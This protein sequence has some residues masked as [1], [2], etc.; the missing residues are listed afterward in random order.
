LYRCCDRKEIAVFFGFIILQ[1]IPEELP[2]KILAV[3]KPV[4]VN[5]VMQHNGGVADNKFS[6]KKKQQNNH[7]LF[8][9]SKGVYA[10][11]KAALQYTFI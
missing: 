10:I 11:V 7:F 6:G 3:L 2:A 9:C 1:S 8:I 4:Y 5:L